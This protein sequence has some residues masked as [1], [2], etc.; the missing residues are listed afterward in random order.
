MQVRRSQA[1]HLTSLPPGHLTGGQTALCGPYDT[2]LSFPRPA[3]TEEPTRP[4]QTVLEKKFLCVAHTGRKDIWGWWALRPLRGSD[5]LSEPIAAVERPTREPPIRPGVV[6]PWNPGYVA[7]Q[8]R[9]IFFREETKEGSSLEEGVSRKGTCF[10]E[11]MD[12]IL[13]RWA[14]RPPRKV[15]AAKTKERILERAPVEGR[16]VKARK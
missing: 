4:P 7:Y 12:R 8:I 16:R 2:F 13:G 11:G 10:H 9:R 1:V 6:R 5:L 3:K 15:R 14:F